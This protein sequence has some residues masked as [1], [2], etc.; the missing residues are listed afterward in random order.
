MH[1]TPL[2]FVLGSKTLSAGTPG[3]LRLG[4]PLL[5]IAVVNVIGLPTFGWPITA[6]IFVGTAHSEPG[7]QRE[8][9]SK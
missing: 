1:L 2:G 5:G 4:S 6:E 8:G 9:F 7:S 3:Q